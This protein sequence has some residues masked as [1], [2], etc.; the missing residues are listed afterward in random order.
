MGRLSKK[1]SCEG[2]LAASFNTASLCLGR[3]YFL[4][5]FLLF[6]NFVHVYH[7][8]WSNPLPFSLFSLLLSPD[9]IYLPTSYAFCFNSLSQCSSA[10]MTWGRV[11]QPESRWPLRSYILE[12]HGVSLCSRRQLLANSSSAKGDTHKSLPPM[13]GFWNAWSWT[14]F[15]KWLLACF[16]IN[17]SLVGGRIF[18]CNFIVWKDI[19]LS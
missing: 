11:H 19:S 9:H 18:W 13:L 17:Y 15:S 5:I 6:E 3:K 12:E 4:L 16:E 10:W 1:L 7:V 2:N 8:F 14:L